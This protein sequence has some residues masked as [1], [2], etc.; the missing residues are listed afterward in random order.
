M[1]DSPSAAAAAA[2]AEKKKR[3]KSSVLQNFYVDVRIHLIA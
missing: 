1:A 3:L 2:A